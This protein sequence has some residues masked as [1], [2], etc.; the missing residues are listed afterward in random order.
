MKTS[1]DHK[2]LVNKAIR[3]ANKVALVEFEYGRDSV[4]YK[5]VIAKQNELNKLL[6]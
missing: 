4:E 3:L 2:N 1:N 5:K 6:A